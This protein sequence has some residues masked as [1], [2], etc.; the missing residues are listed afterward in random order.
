MMNHM[1]EFNGL[2]KTYWETID[3][4]DNVFI[5]GNLTILA[6]VTIGSNVIITAGSLVNMDVPD[7]KIVGSVPARAIGETANLFESRRQYSVSKRT[8]INYAERLRFLFG[9][10]RSP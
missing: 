5:G 2:E 1:P 4:G 3:I 10:E 8:Q 7:G 9:E 6:D